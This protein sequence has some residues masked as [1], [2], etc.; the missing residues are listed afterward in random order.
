MSLSI[1]KVALQTQI[2]LFPKFN[3]FQNMAHPRILQ[4]YSAFYNHP[5]MHY[6]PIQSGH[7]SLCGTKSTAHGTQHGKAHPRAHSARECALPF[8][9]PRAVLLVRR[10]DSRP[11]RRPC[12]VAPLFHCA[13]WTIDK[14]FEN[15]A[16]RLDFGRSGWA[17]F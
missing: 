4:S 11:D 7:E 1:S 10:K 6:M 12:V 13:P 16:E 15:F 14:K 9:E 17:G 5:H 3:I 8:R 2:R